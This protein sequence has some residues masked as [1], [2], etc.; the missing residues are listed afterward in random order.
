MQK[1]LTHIISWLLYT[2]IF[3]A[4]CAVGL[5]MATERLLLA[6]IPPL[7]IPL[8]FFVFGSTAMVYNAHFLQLKTSERVSDRYQWSLQ[9]PYAHRIVF[10]LGVLLCGGSL[11]WLGWQILL[12]CVLLGVLSFG[13]SLP[14]LLPVGSGIKLR[15]FGWV[16]ILLLTGVWTIVTSI[17][18]M[19]Y[20]H[21]PIADYP[22]EILLRFV[23]MFVLCVAFDIR[24]MQTDFKAGIYTLP[25]RIGLQNS[26]R[27]MYGFILLFLALSIVQYLRYPSAIRLGAELITA[28]ITWRVIVYTRTHTSDKIYLG[29]VD[30]MMLLYALLVLAH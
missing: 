10:G 23:F 6:D 24:D 30:G 1:L 26:Y 13:Y 16:K 19:L 3:A 25:N 20:W 15:D 27:L 18:P 12:A 2:S 7:F 9:Y 22:F 14:L 21:V 17:L 28:F 5:C 8:H 29:L 11:F 4:C